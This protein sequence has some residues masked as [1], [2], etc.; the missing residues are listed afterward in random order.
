MLVNIGGAGKASIDKTT[1]YGAYVEDGGD[2]FLNDCNVG[3]VTAFQNST[4]G[5]VYFKNCSLGSTGNDFLDYST[6]G[7]VSLFN[8]HFYGS[9]TLI[10]GGGWADAQSSS[11][12]YNYGEVT[13]AVTPLSDTL[14]Y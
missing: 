4:T 3:F 7:P 12:T 9:N 2:I 5:N 13:S 11:N 6:A 14:V 1:V 8:L 10:P